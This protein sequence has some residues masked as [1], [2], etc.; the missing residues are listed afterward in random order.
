[1]QMN[2]VQITEHLW[3]NKIVTTEMQ[4]L[5][6]Y[7]FCKKSGIC[8]SLVASISTHDV[9][10]L[11]FSTSH[12]WRKAIRRW[13]TLILHVFCTNI[14]WICTRNKYLDFRY[15]VRSSFFHTAWWTF[16]HC[17]S[18]KWEV[19]KERQ[20]QRVLKT[21]KRYNKFTNLKA[22]MSLLTAY[23]L[24]VFCM[25]FLCADFFFHF[26]HEPHKNV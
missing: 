18:S 3:K 9:G 6:L 17:R 25:W 10:K 21:K 7:S 1:M 12:A 13:Y 24:I 23:L 14:I 15:L 26:P 8:A 19:K 11:F 16:Q 2:V 4:G 20:Q 22:Q 5:V